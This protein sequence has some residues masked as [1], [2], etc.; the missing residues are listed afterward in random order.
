MLRAGAPLDVIAL[1][2]AVGA[3]SV[4]GFDSPLVNST[5]REREIDHTYEVE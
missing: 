2:K 4:F 3:I 5:T 1:L